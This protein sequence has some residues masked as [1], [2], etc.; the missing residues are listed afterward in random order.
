LAVADAVGGFVE[1]AKVG[2]K[3][4][5]DVILGSRKVAGILVEGAVSGNRC[6][7]LVAGIG[8]NV[9]QIDFDPSIQSVATSLARELPEAPCRG[10]VLL[11]CLSCLARRL[12]QFEA[13]G[14]A[15]MMAELNARD[16]TKGR[17]VRVA[18]Q[19]GLADGIEEDGRLRV[20]IEGAVRR[21]HAGDVEVLR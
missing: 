8:I 19:Q 12:E 10:E 21:L 15:G 7:H 17:R 9:G 16:V 5:N 18:E 14:L 2:I 13:G 11:A 20:K 1:A 6:E 3:W 4:P